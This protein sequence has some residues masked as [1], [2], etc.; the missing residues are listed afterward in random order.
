MPDKYQERYSAHQERKKSVLKEII[1]T[2]YSNR[3]FEDSVVEQEKID[4][5]VESIQMCPSSCDRHGV[6]AVVISDR[7]AKNLLSGLLVGGTGWVHRASHIIL[8]FA[9][10]QAYKEGL[11]YMPYLDAGVVVM[12]MYNKL[13][14]LGLKGCYV[15]PQV[16]GENQVYFRDRFGTDIYCGAMGVGYGK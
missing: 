4:E 10:P 7:D 6:Y 14:E 15:N 1:Q 5:L 2:H 8:L 13:K 9:D 16:R 11:I 12:N 3:Q